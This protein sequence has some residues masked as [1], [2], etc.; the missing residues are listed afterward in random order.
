MA[1]GIFETA[2]GRLVRYADLPETS[3]KW[4]AYLLSAVEVDGT[5]EDHA[6]VDALFTAPANTEATFTGYTAGG[7]DLVN[8]TVINNAT[9][10]SI[11][12]DNVQWSPTSAEA[13]VKIVLA[14]DP[15]GSDV[16]TQQVPVFHDDF[17]ITTPTSGTITYQVAAGGFSTSS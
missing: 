3:D 5:L 11:D 13:L 12:C 6:T 2:K 10:N 9:D 14:Y 17:E 7:Q 16:Q 15:A 8:V 1:A 4:V